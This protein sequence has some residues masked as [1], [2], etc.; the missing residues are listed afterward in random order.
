MRNKFRE[1]RDS[2]RS[3]KGQFKNKHSFSGIRNSFKL[4]RDSFKNSVK[5]EATDIKHRMQQFRPHSTVTTP[6][7]VGT[8]TDEWY[9]SVRN[10]PPIDINIP[11]SYPA[12]PR[13]D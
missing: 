4:K 5:N 3:R 1:L 6:I 8:N 12:L 2:V 11:V 13:Y 9:N 7:D 10:N